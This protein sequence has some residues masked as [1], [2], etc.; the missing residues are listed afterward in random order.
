MAELKV[1][2]FK[3]MFCTIVL[4]LLHTFATSGQNILLY[5]EDEIDCGSKHIGLVKLY[6]SPLSY[7]CLFFNNTL[8]KTLTQH[9]KIIIQLAKEERI[10]YPRMCRG[11]ANITSMNETANLT[12]AYDFDALGLYLRYNGELMK[13]EL[14]KKVDIEPDFSDASVEILVDSNSDLTPSSHRNHTN[15]EI[16]ECIIEGLTTY[17]VI[18]IILCN[19]FLAGIIIAVILGLMKKH[20]KLPAW[21][22]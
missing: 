18:V 15:I 2:F 6:E 21:I 7:G 11:Q 13:F 4:M 10:G 22:D 9:N 12:F 17:W 5:N 16:S 20:D 14:N 8:N 1:A 3:W 19:L